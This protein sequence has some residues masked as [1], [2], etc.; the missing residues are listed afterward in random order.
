MTTVFTEHLPVV[1]NE[2][3]TRPLFKNFLTQAFYV[4]RSAFDG[5]SDEKAVSF[6]E[7]AGDVKAMYDTVYKPGFL[8]KYVGGSMKYC[9]PESVAYDNGL[10]GI[11]RFHWSIADNYVVGSDCASILLA[12]GGPSY[13]LYTEYYDKDNFD[14]DMDLVTVSLASAVNLG[15]SYPADLEQIGRAQ[16]VRFSNMHIF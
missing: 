15:L 7:F 10:K 13:L 3:A 9:Y 14:V 4:K 12:H 6:F 11:M 1:E 5:L 8:F 2:A 16:T